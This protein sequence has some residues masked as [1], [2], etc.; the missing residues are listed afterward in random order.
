MLLKLLRRLI[1]KHHR[2][3]NSFSESPDSQELANLVSL[4]GSEKYDELEKQAQNLLLSYPRSG[5]VWKVLGATLEVQGKDS[6]PAMLK[7]VELS[8]TDEQALTNF[9][10]ALRKRNRL[11]EAAELYRQALNVNPENVDSLNVL[12]LILLDLGELSDAEISF[13]KAIE[14]N[15]GCASSHANLGIVLRSIGNFEDAVKQFLIALSIDPLHANS[16]NGYGAALMDQGLFDLAE[17]YFRLAVQSNPNYTDAQNNLAYLMSKKGYISESVLLLKNIVDSGEWR[18]DVYDNLLYILTSSQNEVTASES[19]AIARQYGIGVTERAQRYESWFCSVCKDRRIRIGLVSADFRNHP[20]GYFIEGIIKSLS[21]EHRERFEI[22]VYSNSTIGDEVTFR[23]E[24]SCDAWKVIFGL[25]DKDAAKLIHDDR[26][27]ILVDLSGHTSGNRLPMFAWKPAPIQVSWLGYWGTTGV[28]EIDFIIADH[29]TLPDKDR[30]QFTEKIWYLPE[31]R[32]CFTRPAYK[33]SIASL[34]AFAN[35]Y[36]TFGCFNRLE[37]INDEV[38]SLWSQIL[39]KVPNSRLLIKAKQ[40]NEPIRQ[41]WIIQRFEK[42]GIPRVR[43]VLEGHSGRDEY[44]ATYNKVDMALD[45][46]PFT[47]G[48]TTVEALW[49]GVPVMTLAGDSML[50]RQGV[51]LLMNANLPQYIATSKEDYVRYSVAHAS[52]WDSLSKIRFC[53]RDQVSASSIFDSSRFANY[54][55][56]AF[57]EMWDMWRLKVTNHI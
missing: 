31:T 10:L 45:P 16:C 35:G 30:W 36:V 37:K 12:G 13:R 28:E 11:N 4:F 43:I 47:G 33:Y 9:G 1:F 7:A 27:D 19:L 22:I 14:I 49:M 18:A 52:D 41:D 3:T 5:F 40:L 44:L 6:L 20:V 55:S 57:Y 23:I 32:L 50:S 39:S 42:C 17:K 26:I 25:Q 54:L 24:S 38:I 2:Q 46:F 8:N 51:G 53:L 29:W 21:I 15:N 56:S 34:P 48:T